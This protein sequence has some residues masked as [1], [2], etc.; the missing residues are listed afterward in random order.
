MHWV[1]CRECDMSVPCVVVLLVKDCIIQALYCTTAMVLCLYQALWIHK[2]HVWLNEEAPSVTLSL[3]L[4]LSLSR[5]FCL[6]LSLRLPLF[7]CVS[8]TLSPL[9]L[10]IALYLALSLCLSRSLYLW[11]SLC[12]SLHLSVSLCVSL[13]PWL[14]SCLSMGSIIEKHLLAEA[15]TDDHGANAYQR[16]PL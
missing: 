1:Y 16:H 3:C 5:Y 10:T 8:L 4:S 7:L 12:V 15:K 13:F 2:K 11:L 9:L 14:Q 6:S